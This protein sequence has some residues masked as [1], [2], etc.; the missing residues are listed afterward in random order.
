MKKTM[1]WCSLIT[2]A[3]CGS[4]CKKEPTDKAG[5]QLRK[6]VEE[7]RDQQKDVREEQKDVVKE[8]KDVAKE[9]RDVAKEQRE[10]D[11]AEGN[12]AQARA[13]YMTTTRERLAAI[14]GKIAQL[15]ARATAKAKDAAIA[16]RARRNALATKL[17]TADSRAEAEWDKFRTDVED[18]FKQ[19]EK[20][21]KDALD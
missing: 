16:L 3:L 4:A 7:V 13:N 6:S 9:Q 19:I 15:E 2:A 17:D 1:L 21:A 12:L 5:D 10:L 20:D 11:K 18:T 8:Q 14:D